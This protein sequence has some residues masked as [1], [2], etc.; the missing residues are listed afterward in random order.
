ME[1]SYCID[2]SAAARMRLLRIARSSI[3]HGLVNHRPVVVERDDLAGVLGEPLG[4]FVTLRHQ[5]MLRGCVGSLEPVRPLGSAVAVAAYNAAFRDARFPPLREDE[6][7]GI[8]IE[9]SVLSPLE[10]MT[11]NDEGDLLAQIRPGMDG[12]VIEDAGRRATFLPK[13]WEQLA[14]PVD[15]LRAL[16]LKAGLPEDYWS[17]SVRCH[18]YRS[19][20]FSD[21]EQAAPMV[22]GAQIH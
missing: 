2:L 21:H 14:E 19:I 5:Q 15:F 3:S 4:T 20:C 11:V 22:A 7:H 18:R 17:D 1:P 9:V 13:V 10:P 12:L 16:K 8:D 6:L